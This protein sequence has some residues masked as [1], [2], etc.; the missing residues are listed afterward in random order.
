MKNYFSY[1]ESIPDNLKS[2]IVYKFTY[3]SCSFSYIGETCCHFKTTIEEH[4]KKNDK[5]IFLNTYTPPQHALIQIILFA[6][7]QLIRQT[8]NST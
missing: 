2:F 4:I 5:F 3:G 8:L 7:K 1:K 6:L